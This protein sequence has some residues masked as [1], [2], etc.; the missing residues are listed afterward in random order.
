MENKDEDIRIVEIDDNEDY[1]L[2]LDVEDTENKEIDYSE[3]YAED[4]PEKK[5]RKIFPV[6]IIC[7]V[8]VTL[9]L[10]AVAFI[11]DRNRPSKEYADL[12][13]YY[14]V[15]Q[16]MMPVVLDGEIVGNTHY[17]QDGAYL[18]MD[19][20]MENI[21]D[22]FYYDTGRNMLLYTTDTRIYEI[23]FDSAEF[24][25]S[26]GNIEAEC[27][28]TVKV[29]D[30]IYISV[31]F[32]EDKS[33]YTYK[34]AENPKRLVIMPDETT[35]SSIV[36]NKDAKIRTEASV[37]APIISDAGADE[38][39]WYIVTDVAKKGWSE[40]KC[41]DGRKGFVKTDEIMSDEVITFD[42]GYEGLEYTSCKK[43]YDIVLM[44]HAIYNM[45]ANAKI[46][47]L[48]ADS[49]GVTTVSPTW[50][51]IANE[52]GDIY[53]MADKAYVDYVHSL[54]MEIWP[55]IS[56]FTSAE[57]NGWNIH[58]L[59]NNT[60]NRR[61]LIDN[62]MNEID[63]YGYDGINIDFEYIKQDSADGFIQFIRELSIRCR[64]EQVVLS[65]DNYVPKAHT[66]HYNRKAQGECADYVIVMSYDEHYRGGGV[67]GSVASISFVE[68]GILDT[69]KEVPADKLING[70]PF[71]TRLWMETTDE[72]G[73]TV[74]DAVSYSMEAALQMVETLGLTMEWDEEVCQYV[75]EGDVNGVHYSIWLEEERSMAAKMKLVRDNKLSGIAAWSLGME[76]KEI[77]DVLIE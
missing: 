64:E 44:W 76:K 42:S 77:W 3:F 20:V 7:V 67:A 31:D 11:V 5:R 65:I 41:I 49:K 27:K 8:L 18:S 24:T 1:I 72:S 52:K 66:K 38:M 19:F 57:P 74:L 13:E 10:A 69:L 35:I 60:Q 6:I 48:L 33:F 34:I 55:L 58:D 28:I 36:F 45:D 71:Y 43:D 70:I 73:K 68:E 63:N 2:D 62:I 39:N 61:K 40:V 32:L 4:L 25:V 59:F 14:G 9:A 16:D 50:Y 15:E 29:D 53:T 56:D 54:G 47:E 21:N 26:G 37:K 17:S 22:R 75:A 23:P 51:K 46:S 30:I 12:Y